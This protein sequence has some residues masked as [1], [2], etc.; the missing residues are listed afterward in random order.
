MTNAL[1][2]AALVAALVSQ[3]EETPPEGEEEEEFPFNDDQL[4]YL[5]DMKQEL[6]EDLAGAGGAAA[7]VPTPAT[8]S[9]LEL[10]A[11]AYLKW[12]YRNNAT[13]GCVTYGNPHPLGDN[14]SGDNGACPEFSLTITGRPMA[15]IEASF[16]IQ[17]RFG[18][19]FADYFENGD[20]RAVPDSSSESLGNN[21]SAPLQLR[22][23]YV[24]VARPLPLIDWFLVGSDDLAHFDAWTVGKVRFI[25]RFNS[26]G[27][28][29]QTSFGDYAQLLLSRIALSKLYGT[30]NY[31]SL[32]DPLVTNPFWARDAIYAT[33]FRTKPA[34]ADWLTI[35]AN[36]GV[37]LD[38]EADVR[39][40]DAAGSVNTIDPRDGVTA[41][42]SRFLS[43]NASLTAKMTFDA[44]KATGLFAFSHNDPNLD[45]VTNLALGGLGFSN[46][47]Y[48]TT[49]DFAGTARFELPDLLW[50]GSTLKAEYFNIGS[51]FNAVVG[52][53][54]EDDVLLTDGFLD[55]GQLPTLNLANELIDFNDRFYESIV[56]WHGGTLQ[57]E[58]RA[59]VIDFA[60]EGT[61]ITYNTNAQDRDMDIFP[62]FGGFTGY[63]DT[64]LFSYANTNDRGRDPRAVYARDQDR[65]SAIAMVRTTLK[66]DL[67][68][69]FALDVKAKYIW[70]QDNRDLDTDLDDYSAQ[71]FIT[72]ASIGARPLDQLTM[73]I[74]MGFDYWI[75]NGRSG[76]YAGGV[77][78][79]LDYNTTRLRP[80]LDVRYSLGAVSAA[81]HL[82]MVKKNV[83][84]SDDTQDVDTGYIWRSVGWL[85]AQF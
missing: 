7:P 37:V 81:Y 54:R 61:F 12:L 16:R 73:G 10:K 80:F 29:L 65:L 13:Q 39:D 78:D 38:E 4:D 79:F 83:D 15:Q 22:G 27:I 43:V 76:T 69:G 1:F 25:E 84:T 41:V 63:T 68:P 71:L 85:S 46:I 72:E 48:K 66:P 31:S 56:G 3:T 5:E 26:K 28:F 17:S 57:L 42:A 6:R 77:P 70:D 64:Q 47:V 67:W 49:N 24:R 59:D 11:E 75:E 19:Q 20:K 50:E 14:Y 23:I 52:A 30:A 53:R 58:S 21:H 74:G 32:E 60:L 35:I 8:P 62:G 45:Y 82:E 33:S 55:G 40:P 18:Q 34:M 36:A 2:A 51:E 9:A 44:F